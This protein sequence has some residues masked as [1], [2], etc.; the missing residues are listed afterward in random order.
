MSKITGG[1]KKTPVWHLVRQRKINGEV[2]I[3]DRD[4]LLKNVVPTLTATQA[5]GSIY[6]YFENELQLTIAYAQ[7]EITVEEVTP[8]IEEMMDLHGDRCVVVV[9]GLVHLEDTR[10]FEYTESIHRL[11][12]FRFVEFARRRKV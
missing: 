3:L 4:Y 6:E 11:D 5:A 8:E 12:K 9:R 7:K 1:N 2:V 10:C